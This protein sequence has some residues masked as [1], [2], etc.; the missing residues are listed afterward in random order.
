LPTNKV[1]KLLIENCFPLWLRSFFFA[2]KSDEQ[3][4]NIKSYDPSG[5]ALGS[6][7]QLSRR[8]ANKGNILQHLCAKAVMGTAVQVEPDPCNFNQLIE[9]AK[10]FVHSHPHLQPIALPMGAS[11]EFGSI[12]IADNGEASSLHATDQ[13]SSCETYAVTVITLDHMLP[14]SHVVFVKID[15]EG[16]DR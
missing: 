5:L 15:V 3:Q 1:A 13:A 9:K 2:Y 7:N 10:N 12:I 11:S 4:Y 8:G 16:N 14:A 6:S